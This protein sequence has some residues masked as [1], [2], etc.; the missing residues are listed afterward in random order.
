[1]E[2]KTITKRSGEAGKCSQ[3]IEVAVFP[4]YINW[5]PVIQE[6]IDCGPKAESRPHS[7]NII[8]LFHHLHFKKLCNIDFRKCENVKLWIVDC[9]WEWAD[10][11][12][13]LRFSFFSQVTC[14]SMWYWHLIPG[15]WTS[16]TIL[17]EDVNE[18]PQAI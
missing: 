4:H 1:M 2:E 11:R 10:I 8:C 16:N 13:L 3:V 7:A 15:W 14:L 18:I 6:E 9:I 5:I 12:N 17:I